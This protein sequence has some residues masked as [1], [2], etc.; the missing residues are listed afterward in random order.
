MVD[1]LTEVLDLTGEQAREQ[2]LRIKAR[3]P[4]PAGVRQ[5]DFLPV[6]VLLC[7]ALFQ[8]VKPNRFGGGNLHLLPKN[9]STLAHAL[10]R[11]PGSLT[12][13]MLNLEGT[14]KNGAR[15]E[16]ELFI[17]LCREPERFE[18]LY[19]R[20]IR[21]AREAGLGENSVPDVL[22]RDIWGG[23]G[24]L[25][26]DEIRSQWMDKALEEGEPEAEDMAAR[27][28]MPS[29]ETTYLLEQRVR[30]GQDRFAREVLRNYALSCGFCGFSA[31]ELPKR[32][33]IIASHI[34][35]WVD[36]TDEERLDPRN[37]IAACPV[38]DKAFDGGLLTVN[39]GMKIH[40]ADPLQ[41]LV[42]NDPL[43]QRY[44][45]KETVYER[46][47]LPPGTSASGL[48]L[49]KYLE[50]HKAN[51]FNRTSPSLGVLGR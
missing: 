31:R 45:G 29:Q 44:F 36:S 26:Q 42:L 5:E 34:K 7:F 50:W 6:E 30:R 28:G 21:G 51:V 15:H 33:L 46:L 11:S 38:H 16:P 32:G 20:V 1:R 39:G 27:L 25:G 47:T 43:M 2:W 41:R 40:R 35:S 49:Q 9:V 19:D 4:L 8:V 24:L 13:K 17:R 10:A 3:P 14:R 48:P 18:E 23:T 12:S 22:D 37:G